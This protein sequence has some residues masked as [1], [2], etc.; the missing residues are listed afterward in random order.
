MLISVISSYLLM[1]DYTVLFRFF[2]KAQHAYTS[3]LLPYFSGAPP[4]RY[5]RGCLS[6]YSLQ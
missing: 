6:G 3:W 1:F 5:L 2:F 4:Q